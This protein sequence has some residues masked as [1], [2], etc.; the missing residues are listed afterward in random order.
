MDSYVRIFS[1]LG[2]EDATKRKL[3]SRQLQGRGMECWNYVTV[4][5]PEEKISG[6]KFQAKFEAKFISTTQKLALFKKF[7]ELR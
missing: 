2:L 6:E 7:I 5:T 4:E 3:A 1:D